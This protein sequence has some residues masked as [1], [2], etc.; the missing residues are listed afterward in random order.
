M[1]TN[2]VEYYMTKHKVDLRKVEGQPLLV[3]KKNDTDLFLPSSLC[4]IASLDQE[5]VDDKK[6]MEKLTP[7]KLR[8][9]FERYKRIEK[10]NSTL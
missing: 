9:P 3:V 7:F 10:F 4:Q 8:D 6:R 1:K 2:L 5:F